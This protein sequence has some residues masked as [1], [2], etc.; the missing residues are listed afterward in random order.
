MKATAR[1]ITVPSESPSFD[2]VEHSE[3][4]SQWG[5]TVRYT[6]FPLT[7]SEVLPRSPPGRPAPARGLAGSCLSCILSS[8][9]CVRSGIR[10]ISAASALA[11]R[12]PVQWRRAYQSSQ[13]PN[14]FRLAS[15]ICERR[16]LAGGWSRNRANNPAVVIKYLPTAPIR[17]RRARRARRAAAGG[18]P[19]SSTRRSGGRG[20]RA[21]V[22]GCGAA[23]TPPRPA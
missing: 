2:A 17:P 5:E 22:A 13:E 15:W 10:V 8:S 11:P 7:D 19:R 6:Y 4:G 23:L 3:R 20:I 12:L 16:G 1:P 21:E 18:C 14:L 9:L